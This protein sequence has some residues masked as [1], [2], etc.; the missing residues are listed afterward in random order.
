MI[1]DKKGWSEYNNTN[2]IPIK[3]DLTY[4]QNPYGDKIIGHLKLDIKNDLTGDDTALYRIAIIPKEGASSVLKGDTGDGH[5][6][7]DMYFADKNGVRID[8]LQLV[9]LD[10]F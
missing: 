4:L 2:M 5:C 1:E 8:E 9:F 3:T 7:N 6:Y 10:S